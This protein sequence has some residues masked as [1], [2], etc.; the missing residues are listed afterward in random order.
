MKYMV[1]VSINNMKLKP[2]HET[3]DKM[4]L[5]AGKLKFFTEVGYIIHKIERME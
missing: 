5:F 4:T 1:H 2:Y 3:I